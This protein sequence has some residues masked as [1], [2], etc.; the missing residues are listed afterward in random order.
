MPRSKDRKI[1]SADP[2][3][4]RADRKARAPLER[5]TY[6]EIPRRALEYHQRAKAKLAAATEKFPDL[7]PEKNLGVFKERTL[8]QALAGARERYG[9]LADEELEEIRMAGHGVRSCY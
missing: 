6:R 8:P 5:V 7:P 3:S 9:H 2:E 4:D 1:I